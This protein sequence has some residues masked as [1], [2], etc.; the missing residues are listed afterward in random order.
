MRTHRTKTPAAISMI[1]ID[2][3]TTFDLVGP[4]RHG[5]IVSRGQG[6]C[7]LAHLPM[8]LAP[9]T[10]MSSSVREHAL[11]TLCATLSPSAK[12]RPALGIGF[13]TRKTVSPREDTVEE[14]P[15]PRHSSKAEIEERGSQKTRA[16]QLKDRCSGAASR[17]WDHAVCH[18]PRKIA[19]S[20]SQQDPPHRPGDRGIRQAAVY[21]TTKVFGITMPLTLRRHSPLPQLL[22]FAPLSSS[23]DSPWCRS[24]RV[25][26]VSA[27]GGIPLPA[28]REPGY[29]LLPPDLWSKVRAT[30]CSA[31]APVMLGED[32]LRA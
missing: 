26:L 14:P 8:S 32:R 27:L 12:L 18:R 4:D 24:S 31:T 17:N 22:R 9:D 7:W 16:G 6:D 10:F 29:D 11:S 5:A 23:Q 1:G 20:V 15:H 3:G 25:M 13:A 2:L 30:A 28:E 21:L 19:G